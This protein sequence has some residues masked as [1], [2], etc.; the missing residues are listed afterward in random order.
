[1]SEK[2]AEKS[3][4]K[5]LAGQ[6]PGVQNADA[7]Q[8]Q[9]GFIKSYPN[10]DVSAG[11][12]I[13]IG[14]ILAVITA[15]GLAYG[16]AAVNP[17]D[18]VVNEK[19]KTVRV[20]RDLDGDGVTG[21]KRVWVLQYVSDLVNQ[22]G[23]VQWLEVV[24]FYCV[25][26][27]LVMKISAVKKQ[28]AFGTFAGRL[29][30]VNLENDEELQRFRK[31][32]VD[33]GLAGRSILF[34]RLERAIALWLSSKDLGRVTGWMS[35]ESSR[36]ANVTDMTYTIPRTMMWAIPIFGFIGTVQGLSSAVGG[37]A[38][39]LSGAA[40][41]AAIKGAIADVTIGLGVAFDT[42]FLA[43]VLVAIVQF[44]L[45]GLQRRE[46]NL[47][48]NID[49]FLG[50]SFADRLP[51]AEQQAVVI[52]NLEDSIESAFRRYIP[53]PDRYEEVFTASIEKAGSEVEKKFAEFTKDY[54]DARK[55]S[56]EAEVKSLADAL[57][58]AHEKAAEL[59]ATYMHSADNIRETLK[60]SLDKAS[61][62]TAGIG[63]QMSKLADFGQKINELLQAESAMEKAI[64]G[65]AGAQDFQQTFA[66]L[67]THLKETDDFCRKLSRPRVIT[68]REEEG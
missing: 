54:I 33:E 67:R 22:R 51:S 49:S 12:Q 3:D 64:A 2:L 1:M 23:P 44:P 68:F 34:S 18:D 30:D 27:F 5:K 61:E 29:Q 46:S 28:E 39:F 58:R 13:L 48:G 25:V 11:M 6:T 37:F 10:T 41:L 35:G 24:A 66:D 42:T 57:E 47:F 21:D 4:A 38:D 59:G 7:V 31:D 43:L 20:F 50:E 36:D 26:V 17:Y 15:F 65:I 16:N 55:A 14:I 53:D 60:G 56:T 9:E 63:D 19:G 8:G 32:L 45:A 62:A 52:E 40:E